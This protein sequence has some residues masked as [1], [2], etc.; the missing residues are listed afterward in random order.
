MMKATTI[1]EW[2][3]RSCN[4]VP[5]LLKFVEIA[6]DYTYAGGVLDSDAER[7]GK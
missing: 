6:F 1:L 4:F 5:S 3:R 7:G 2:K